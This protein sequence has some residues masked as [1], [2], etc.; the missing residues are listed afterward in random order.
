M[1]VFLSFFFAGDETF[2]SLHSSSHRLLRLGELGLELLLAHGEH[3]CRGHR[4]VSSERKRRKKG[5]KQ[6]YF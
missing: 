1:E 5:Y 4:V 6:F 2:S 3:L